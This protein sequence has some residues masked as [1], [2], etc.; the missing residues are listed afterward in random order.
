MHILVSLPLKP[1]HVIFVPLVV[2]SGSISCD[3]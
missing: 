3:P 2:L 1:G